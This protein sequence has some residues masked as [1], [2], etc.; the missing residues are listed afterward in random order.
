MPYFRGQGK[1]FLAKRDGNGNPLAFRYLGLTSEV[2]AGLT[3]QSTTIKETDSG[4][5]LPSL[6]YDTDTG[7][8]LSFKIQNI[9]KENWGL[10]FAG[11]PQAIA[12]ARSTRLHRP[13][14]GGETSLT[15]R[16]SACRLPHG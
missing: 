1:V 9:T 6:R 16:R 4:Q 2:Q 13:S 5:R 10:A 14:A 8:T 15:R 7:A 11:T 12:A 3:K